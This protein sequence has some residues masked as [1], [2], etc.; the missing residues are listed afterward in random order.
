[1][2]DLY[3]VY[4]TVTDTY[5]KCWRDRLTKLMEALEYAS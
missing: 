2:K 4:Y 1:M 5:C 3:N